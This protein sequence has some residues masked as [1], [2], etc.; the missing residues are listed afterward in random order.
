MRHGWEVRAGLCGRDGYLLYAAE[1]RREIL[2]L[3]GWILGWFALLSVDF[4]RLL[5]GPDQDF[6]LPL[7]LKVKMLKTLNPYT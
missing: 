4:G 6:G 5:G 2:P 1:R 3:E 7:G